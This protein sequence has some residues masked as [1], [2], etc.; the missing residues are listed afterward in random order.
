MGVFRCSTYS[1]TWCFLT[2]DTLM[3]FTDQLTK[4]RKIGRFRKDGDAPCTINSIE[5]A[6]PRYVSECMPVCLD[7]VSECLSKRLIYKKCACG[8]A[9]SE[10]N[11]KE[12]MSHTECLNTCISQVKGYLQT[13]GKK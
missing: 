13:N 12:A 9:Y 11:M 1:C 2:Q 5:A 4:L 8:W 6:T 3:V 7:N 10:A